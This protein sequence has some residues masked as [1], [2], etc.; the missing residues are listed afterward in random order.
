MTEKKAKRL[1]EKKYK[2]LLKFFKLKERNEYISSKI[3]FDTSLILKND[4]FPLF[5]K[6]FDVTIIKWNEIKLSCPNTSQIIGFVTLESSSKSSNENFYENFKFRSYNN[7]FFSNSEIEILGK[8]S[9]ISKIFTTKFKLVKKINKLY[10]KYITETNKNNLLLT[11]IK[12]KAIDEI[13]IYLPEIEKI[14]IK[15]LQ[16]EGILFNEPSIIQNFKI[17]NEKVSYIKLLEINLETRYGIVDILTDQDNRYSYKNFF[18]Q[19]LIPFIQD[20]IQKKNVTN[21]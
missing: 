10:F 5:K 12:T 14:I 21:I 1:L 18:V 8:L 9:N 19:D 11:E 7:V 2:Y 17:P 16:T 15:K 20:Q 4:F 13:D 6:H 3:K